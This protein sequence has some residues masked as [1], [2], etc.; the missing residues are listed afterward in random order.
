MASNED[1]IGKFLR[2]LLQ[3]RSALEIVQSLARDERPMPPRIPGGSSVSPDVV[4]SRWQI[5]N[6]P[7]TA[8]RALL[9]DSKTLDPYQQKIENCSGTVKIPIGQEGPLRIK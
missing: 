1:R 9:D 6:A 3:R 7:D 8:R 5:L 4:E 2:R